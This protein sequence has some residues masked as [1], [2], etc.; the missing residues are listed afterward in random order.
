MK[1]TKLKST[2]IFRELTQEELANKSGVNIRTIQAIE[3]GRRDIN[4]M[5]IETAYKL[6][7]AL[8]VAP[9]YFLDLKRIEMPDG[10]TA[11]E[12]DTERNTRK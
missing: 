5:T 8:K 4:H 2:R 3:S 11:Q 10:R 7:I 6:G 1:Y 9:Q 12:W